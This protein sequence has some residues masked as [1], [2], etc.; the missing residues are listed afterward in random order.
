[1]MSVV[2]DNEDYQHTMET[3]GDT[4][5]TTSSDSVATYKTRYE[6]SDDEDTDNDDDEVVESE[7]SDELESSNDDLHYLNF[8]IANLARN[9]NITP[10]K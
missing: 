10:N 4:T 8:F 2:D 7:S 1:M 3:I 9:D 6:Y 5:T